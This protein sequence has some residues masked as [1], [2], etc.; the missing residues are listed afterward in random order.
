MAVTAVKVTSNVVFRVKLGV[1]QNGNDI[2]RAVTLR[3]VRPTAADQ[4]IFDVVAAMSGL[5]EG[6]VQ[7]V[8]R[9]DVSQL[10][11]A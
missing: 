11:N 10:I 5:L 4:D 3:R 2:E 7:N 9:Q 1:D 6:P 8:V